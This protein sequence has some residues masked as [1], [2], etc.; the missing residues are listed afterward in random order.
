MWQRMSKPDLLIYLDVD[1]DNAHQRRPYQ[2]GGAQ[3]NDN[4]NKILTHARQHCDFYLNTNGL[5]PLEVQQQ[6]ATFLQQYLAPQTN[7]PTQ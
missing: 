1:Y 6:T 2:G 5:S 4:Q 7:I 3:R